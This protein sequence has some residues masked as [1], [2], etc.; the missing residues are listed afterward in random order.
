MARLAASGFTSMRRVIDIS[1]DGYN[2][3]G[4]EVTD[5]RNDAVKAGITINGLPI[6]ND[7]PNPFGRPAVV[8]LD[9][10]Y[11]TN[12][13]GGPGA[14]VVVA[15][16]YNSFAAA[17]LS[18]LLL[19]I[20][21]DQPPSREI[22]AAAIH[23]SSG[24]LLDQEPKQR[25]VDEHLLPACLALVEHADVAQA[26]EVSRGGLTLRHSGL[27]QVANSAVRLHEDQVDELP[28]ID[29]WQLAPDRLGHAVEEVA[30]HPDLGRR[31]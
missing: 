26:L 19:E 25:V 1:G 16:D 23:Q 24:I 15:K 30:D 6:I 10:Y 7:R 2:N 20:A 14:F 3:I 11:E 13:I 5:A 17:I 9:K 8:D 22:A 29:L 21:S 18:K 12:V 27:N 31:P 28:R 4:R